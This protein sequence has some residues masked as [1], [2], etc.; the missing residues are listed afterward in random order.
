[1]K[2]KVEEYRKKKSMSQEI[3]SQKAT[4]SRNTIS[5]LER[6]PNTNVTKSVMERIAGALEEKVSTIF[7]EE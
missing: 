1:M 2:N 6:N 3:L 5:Q 7:F 4:V